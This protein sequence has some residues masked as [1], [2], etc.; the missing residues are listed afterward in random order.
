MVRSRHR[1]RANRLR[2]AA[3][4][5]GT[6]GAAMLVLAGAAA[7]VSQAKALRR[8]SAAQDWLRQ[9][10]EHEANQQWLEAA[11]A[12]EAYLS[13]EPGAADQRVRLA[14]LYASGTLDTDQREHAIDLLYRAL[15]ICRD[16]ER[17][18]LQ[19]RL[20]EFLLAAERF[21]E[22]EAQ[23]NEVIQA[24]PQDRGALR[25]RALA[26]L[27]Q[28]K[29]GE[30]DHT[31]SRNLP[32]VAW[33]DEARRANRNDV[34]LAEFTAAAYRNLELGVSGHPSVVARERLGG[35]RPGGVIQSFS[36]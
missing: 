36:F 31:L 24:H 12:I 21:S 2:T 30:L 35:A 7:A 28:Y 32:I 33:L 8:Q 6:L 29:R 25:V 13:L 1:R 9:A 23:A 26:L 11:Q 34:A 20:S 3:R 17:L 22:A 16:D 27:R 15:G 5:L 10:Q 18:P 19:I 14:R 4:W